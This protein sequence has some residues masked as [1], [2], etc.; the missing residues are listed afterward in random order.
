MS[1]DSKTTNAY[2]PHE[3]TG[4]HVF[5]T[6]RVRQGEATGHVRYM[7]VASLALV[8]AAVVILFFFLT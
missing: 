5:G 6:T 4:P 8:A 2:P 3:Q 7:L 1:T